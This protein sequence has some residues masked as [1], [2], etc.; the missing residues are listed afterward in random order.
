MRLPGYRDRV[1]HV[2]LGPDEGGLNL[3]MPPERIAALAGRGRR[4][5]EELAARFAPGSTAKLNWE[6]HRW[7][8]FRSTMAVLEEIFAKVAKRL[9]PAAAPPQP[10]DVPYSALVAKPDPVS[11]DWKRKEQHARAMAAAQELYALAA[12]WTAAAEKLAEGAPR[13]TPELRAR[14]RI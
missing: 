4:A 11:Y 12:G 14:P 9:D 6:N 5:G 13:P 3:A 2:G 7:V 10:G 8:R 1:A